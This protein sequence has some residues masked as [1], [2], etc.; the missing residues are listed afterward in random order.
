MCNVQRG[1]DIN[2]RI[3]E[4]VCLGISKQNTRSCKQV[5]SSLA[6]IEPAE[7]KCIVPLTQSSEP[8]NE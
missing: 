5:L 7:P 2:E 1:M 3:D 8:Y 4:N 6:D